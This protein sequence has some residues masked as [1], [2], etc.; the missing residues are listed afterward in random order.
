MDIVNIVVSFFIGIFASFISAKIFIK[1]NNNKNQPKIEISN[2]IIKTNKIDG[3]ECIQFKILNL[4]NQDLT[5]IEIILVGIKNQAPD[6]NIPIIINE[7]IAN[8]TLTYIARFEKDSKTFPYA[9]RINLFANDIYQ[10]LDRYKELEI[11]I[12]SHCPFY[13]TS[14]IIRKIYNHNDILDKSHQFNSG[15]N[16]SVV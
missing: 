1:H 15:N 8:R 10:T 3:S 7:E 12:R 9:V 4:T 13:E 2:S 14:N 6:K 5:D 11:I 16:T